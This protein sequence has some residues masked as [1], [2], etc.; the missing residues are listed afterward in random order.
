MPH[1]IAIITQ[2][3]PGPESA[4][5][6]Q[7]V[8]GC[9]CPSPASATGAAQAPCSGVDSLHKLP[10]ITRVPRFNLHT[11]QPHASCTPNMLTLRH[12]LQVLPKAA[13]AGIDSCQV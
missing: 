7:A 5:A 9:L 10:H 11:R 3:A 12:V 4:G 2:L 8:V 1:A 13:C 6:S